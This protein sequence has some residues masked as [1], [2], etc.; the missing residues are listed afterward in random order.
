MH[1]KTKADA[2]GLEDVNT[3]KNE[4][5]EYGEPPPFKPG[6]VLTYADGSTAC[7]FEVHE[8]YKQVAHG[9]IP[10]IVTEADGTRHYAKDLKL[11]RS[12]AERQT[13]AASPTVHE[14]RETHPAADRFA[15]AIIDAAQEWERHSDTAASELI[16]YLN[17]QLLPHFAA[18]YSDGYAAGHNVALEEIRAANILAEA[19]EAAILVLRERAAYR[20]DRIS[21]LRHENSTLRH[22]IANALYQLETNTRDAMKEDKSK[23]GAR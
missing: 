2:V 4:R 23:G 9:Y 12:A 13:A 3:T 10:W 1:D 18:A 11:V 15:D 5:H 17:K 21:D 20:Q 16:K 6:D 8:V 19:A 14:T 7:P 22:R